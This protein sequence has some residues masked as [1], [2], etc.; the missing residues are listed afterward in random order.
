MTIG[1]NKTILVTGGAGFIG[2][3]YINKFVPL[4]TEHL[5]VNIDCLTYAGNL[6]NITVGKNKNYYFEKVDIRDKKNLAAIF[7]KYKP[8]GIL[9]F[10]AESHVDISIKSPHLFVE[11]NILGTHNLLSLA[12]EHKIE[13]FHQVSTD[14]VYGSLGP[15]DKPFTENGVLAP[16]SPYSASKSAADLLVRSYHKTYRLNTI[17]TRSS[18]NYG[19]NQDK[20]KLIPLFITNLLENKKVPLYASGDNVRDWIYVEDNIDAIDLVFNK[21]RTGEIYNIGGNTRKTN[22]EITMKL[23]KLA[24]RDESAI[25]HVPDRPGHDFRYALDC[26]KIKKEL[27]WKA[28]TTFDIGIK[29][30]FDFY[31]KQSN[32]L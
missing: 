18:N 13:R 29:K 21:G 9:H 15:K 3:Q 8:T 16:N 24:N 30:T 14:E 5:F 27:G 31:E 10:A 20:S 7:K 17:I 1:K 28:K 26:S 23:L 11:T 6:K 25:E 2:S 12:K 32:Q 19:P 22:L 4:Y